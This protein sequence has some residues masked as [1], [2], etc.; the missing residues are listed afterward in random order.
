MDNSPIL[1]SVARRLRSDEVSSGNEES[2]GWTDIHTAARRKNLKV[3]QACVNNDAAKRDAKTADGETPLMIAA[4]NGCLEVVDWLHRRGASLREVLTNG[5]TVVHYSA[6][7][8]STDTLQYILIQE[9]M[10][11]YVN[12]LNKVSTSMLTENPSRELHKNSVM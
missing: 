8:G 12:S 11:H 10:G 1:L 5:N 2:S 4:L 3:V 9:G 7:S 6:A